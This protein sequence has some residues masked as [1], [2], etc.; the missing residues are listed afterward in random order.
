MLC[1][2]PVTAYGNY[3]MFICV[4]MQYPLNR[5]ALLENIFRWKGD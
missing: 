5:I 2:K 1:K 3:L 4:S